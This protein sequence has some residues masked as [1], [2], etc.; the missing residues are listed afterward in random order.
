MNFGNSDGN[1]NCFMPLEEGDCPH[2]QDSCPISGTQGI[3]PFIFTL[4]MG[5]DDDAGPKIQKFYAEDKHRAK[6]KEKLDM[7]VKGKLVDFCDLLNISISRE[8]VKKEDLSAKLLELPHAQLMFS[9][10]IN[11]RKAKIEKARQLI[12]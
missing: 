10:L 9:L 12:C 1:A 7:C 2:H 6:V 5:M 11:S 3:F 8:S 4:N